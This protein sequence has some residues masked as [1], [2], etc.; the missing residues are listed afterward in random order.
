MS[1]IRKACPDTG[2]GGPDVVPTGR[3]TQVAGRGFAPKHDVVIKLADSGEQATGRT[4]KHGRF[5]IPLIVFPN[6][7]LGHRSVQAHSAHADKSIKAVQP[8]LV[9]LGT[10][11]LPTLVIRH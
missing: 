6:G 1:T 9:V 5:S 8:V 7:I 10:L 2:H 3:L 4:D 11:Q